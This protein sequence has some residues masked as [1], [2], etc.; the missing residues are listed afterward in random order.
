MKIKKRRSDVFVL[1]LCRRLVLLNYVP[2]DEVNFKTS[3]GYGGYD[4]K[5]ATFISMYVTITI[6]IAK[7]DTI[8]TK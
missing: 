6:S 8:R 4:N 2:V 1:D 7:I 3:V 5:L